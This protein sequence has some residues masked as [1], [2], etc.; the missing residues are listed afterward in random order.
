MGRKLGLF[1][2]LALSL[3]GLWIGGMAMPWMVLVGASPPVL[4]LAFVGIVTSVWAGCAPKRRA[5]LTPLL[6]VLAL[7][8]LLSLGRGIEFWIASA[9]TRGSS[10]GWALAGGVAFVA[11]TAFVFY[12]ALTMAAATV[13]ALV[14]KPSD[15]RSAR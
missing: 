3:F 9:D 10:D 4:G 14:R 12:G 2:L 8:L 15:L 5:V 1:A 7:T 13:G 6:A 11:T